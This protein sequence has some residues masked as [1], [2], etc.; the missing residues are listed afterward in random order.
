M[1]MTPDADDQAVDALI[2]AIARAEA[3]GS[4]TARVGA[5]ID[6]G[7]DRSA[8]AGPRFIFIAAALA[9]ATMLLMVWSS[10]H[11]TPTNV[12]STT[13]SSEARIASPPIPPATTSVAPAPS[14]VTAVPRRPRRSARPDDHDRALVALPGPTALAS[15]EIQTSTIETT[16]IDVAPM[17]PI[18]PLTVQTGRDL[19]GRGD[20][21]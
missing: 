3:P 12:P 18:A 16:A 5:A 8:I 11:R 6:A 17:T 10:M 19:S 1:T 14:P 4:L 20:F 2:A 21:R 13:A 15:A 7:G 9:T